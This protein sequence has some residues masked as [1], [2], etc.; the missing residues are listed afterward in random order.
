MRDWTAAVGRYVIAHDI[1]FGDGNI[2]RCILRYGAL[3]IEALLAYSVLTG[4]G[5][6]MALVL[7]EVL[8]RGTDLLTSLV[9][10]TKEEDT[11]SPSSAGGEAHYYGAGLR[12]QYI[13]ELEDGLSDTI[14]RLTQESA[15]LRRIW[16]ADVENAYGQLGLAEG[17]GEE[18]I[19]KAYRRLAVKYHPD[20]N[21]TLAGKERFLRV[22]K[23]YQ[24]L[25]RGP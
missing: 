14:R 25:L 15:R 2:L 10:A 11:P 19:K 24:M 5:V 4:A 8:V 9:G 12:Q 16:E 18:E 3:L 20:K 13:H 23:A 7:G 6:Q 22:T 1:L 17:A 21:D